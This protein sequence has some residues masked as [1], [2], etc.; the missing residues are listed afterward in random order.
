M[1]LTALQTK[2]N[3][4]ITVVSS[5]VRNVGKLY[6]DNTP[7]DVTVQLIND[8]G[9]VVNVTIP[10]MA[11]VEYSFTLWKEEISKSLDK[12]LRTSIS[13]LNA[14]PLLD[15]VSWQP[16][17]LNNDGTINGDGS[18]GVLLTGGTGGYLDLVI[19]Y[20]VV[21][22]D[23][24][25]EGH[26]ALHGRLHP[27]SNTYDPN[28]GSQPGQ[29]N[30][31]FAKHYNIPVINQGI[32]GQ[33]S[34]QI[35]ERWNRDVLAQTVDV[36]DGR[37]SNTLEFGGQKPFA[38]YLHIGIN[39][40]FLGLSE[41]TI[42]DN[43]E[44]FAQSCKDNGISLLV[45]N[46]GADSVYDDT[47]ETLARNL[48]TWLETTFKSTYPEVELV[49]YL[50]WSTD[51]TGVYTNLKAGMFADTVHP[52][53]AGYTDY[54]NYIFENVTT[55]LFLKHIELNSTLNGP[56]SFQ[57]ITSFSLNGENYDIPNSSS[58]AIGLNALAE[59]D[60][61]IY[62]L[63]IT[64]VTTVNGTDYT[65]MAGI[66]AEIG[67]ANV[68]AITPSGDVA[69]GDVVAYGVVFNGSLNS[70]WANKNIQSLSSPVDG[71]AT[72]VFDVPVTH[73]ALN[74]VGTNSTSYNF[75]VG[76]GSGVAAAGITEWTIQ[77]RRIT[78]GVVAS[79]EYHDYQ[80]IAY[81]LQG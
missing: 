32:G 7:D 72:I 39:D 73:L 2:I 34:T 66:K 17:D 63:D 54:A 15:G 56:S 23:S 28:Y 81:N 71:I 40:V 10:N 70:S 75:Y 65:G 37:G 58:S 68:N 33:T 53:T 30:Y 43:F 55:P 25:S 64:G 59:I 69:S 45:A 50:D 47:K 14:S 8:D 27:N 61:P 18:S 74:I 79:A 78:D 1:D 52:T 26:P 80:I 22:G 4:Y 42:K 21:I 44:F 11:K 60:N 12:T 62:R 76:S 31:E 3:N 67:K 13:C 41:N 16:N 29:L 35:R 51:G 49:D 77:V 36:G 38:V 19:P 48:N 20:M 9:N 6:F 57:R 24:I 5:W 46:I